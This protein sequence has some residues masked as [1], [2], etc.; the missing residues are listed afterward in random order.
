MRIQEI[1]WTPPPPQVNPLYEKTLKKDRQCG[2]A[3]DTVRREWEEAEE[4]L[5]DCTL[6]P[7]AL[8]EEIHSYYA[9]T[10]AAFAAEYSR[11]REQLL[12][13]GYDNYD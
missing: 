9:D 2:E 4:F 10:F 1:E 13:L 3:K 7:S 6:L 5:A 12:A 8:K 11:S